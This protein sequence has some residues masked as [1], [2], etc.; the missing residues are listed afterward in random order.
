[1]D[2]R[3]R[4]SNLLFIISGWKLPSSSITRFR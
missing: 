3:K 1:M 2:N 4:G